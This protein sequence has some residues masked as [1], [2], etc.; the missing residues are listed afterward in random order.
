MQTFC[1]LCNTAYD[2]V[3]HLT[4]CPHTWF[5]DVKTEPWR[6]LKET[7]FDLMDN[8]QAQTRTNDFDEL[9][10]LAAKEIDLQEKF[11]ELDDECS[12]I[13]AFM[14]GEKGYTGPPSNL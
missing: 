11:R 12:V 8:Q 5:P 14:S 13:R 2:D 3:D 9:A 1:D 10:A 6:S 4:Y 7:I